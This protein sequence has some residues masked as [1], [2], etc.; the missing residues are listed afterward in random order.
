MQQRAPNSLNQ[1]TGTRRPRH[2]AIL[3]HKSTVTHVRDVCWEVGDAVKDVSG[4]E[5]GGV[6]LNGLLFEERQEIV[7]D[8]DVQIDRHLAP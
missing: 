2:R 1:P 7:S 5:D 3:P 4:V 6:A 8:E